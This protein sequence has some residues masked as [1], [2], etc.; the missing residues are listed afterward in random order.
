[1]HQKYT[2]I[3]LLHL[4][5]KPE[6]VAEMQ[7][8]CIPNVYV[9][10]NRW[11]RGG[12]EGLADRPKSERLPKADDGY[13]RT[14]EEVIAKEPGELRYDFAIWTSDRLRA[15]MEKKTWVDRVNV[16]LRPKLLSDNGPCY[17]SKDLRD[18]LNRKHIEHTHSAPIR[19]M[20]QGKLERYTAR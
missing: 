12:L 1:V 6:A 10:I 9:W 19:P 8:V 18:Y 3:R 5:H 11:R 2:V 15:H 7:A 17:F 16:F 14:L 4:G 20:T 13:S